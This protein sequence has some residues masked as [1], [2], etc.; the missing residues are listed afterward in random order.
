MSSL[1]ILP[2]ASRF[3]GT[4]RKISSAESKLCAYLANG[5]I[6]DFT[7]R[8][9]PHK[10]T[11]I[12][13]QGG[14][15]FSNKKLLEAEVVLGGQDRHWQ[16]WFCLVFF[17]QTGV[18]SVRNGCSTGQLTAKC[19][20]WASFQMVMVQLVWK[21]IL[22]RVCLREAGRWHQAVSFSGVTETVSWDRE[23]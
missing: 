4:R 15:L 1:W 6:W 20:P 14:D 13:Q 22:C 17:F 21:D 11:T 8:Q 2:E 16:S 5:W 3:Q 12:V 10:D 18:C 19:V 7:C 23:I 9:Q